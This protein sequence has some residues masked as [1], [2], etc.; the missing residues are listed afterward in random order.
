MVSP[1][2]RIMV[3]VGFVVSMTNCTA[4]TKQG[5]ENQRI[6]VVRKTGPLL[7]CYRCPKVGPSPR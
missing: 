4:V 1:F 2:F 6:A 5:R 7:A 3:T